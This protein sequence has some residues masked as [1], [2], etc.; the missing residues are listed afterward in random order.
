MTG[1][2]LAAIWNTH[3]HDTRKE[4]CMLIEMIL[5]MPVLI[6]A[7]DPNISMN[8]HKKLWI[9]ARIDKNQGLMSGSSI[10]IMNK[11]Y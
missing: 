3:S 8:V 11:C 5:L 4:G 10:S 2:W 9:R 7:H 1:V 6:F